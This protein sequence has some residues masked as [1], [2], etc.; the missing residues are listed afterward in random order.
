MK[1]RTG[2]PC[3]FADIPAAAGQNLD[4]ARIASLFDKVQDDFKLKNNIV[5]MDLAA[6]RALVG[7]KRP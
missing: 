7:A 5:P 2:L 3:R 4:D 6:V 1:R